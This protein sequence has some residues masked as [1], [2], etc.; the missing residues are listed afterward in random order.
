MEGKN[1]MGTNW[2]KKYDI[3]QSV[4]SLSL[5]VFIA[6]QKQVFDIFFLVQVF[7]YDTSVLSFFVLSDKC[8]I[9]SKYKHLSE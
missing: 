8:R 3:G 9:N 5:L 6:P 7:Y 4:A 1:P 2:E